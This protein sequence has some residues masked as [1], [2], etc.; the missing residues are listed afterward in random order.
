M[1]NLRDLWY[2][3]LGINT[4]LFKKINSLSNEHIYAGIMKKIT[5][6]GQV[7]LLPYYL[8]AIGVYAVLSLLFKLSTRKGG[9]KYHI[10]MWIN[11]FIM[12]GAGLVSTK[13]TTSYLKEYFSYPRPYVMLSSSEVIQLEGQVT[14]EAYQS[15]PSGHVII[16]TVLIAAL[17]P[18]LN[19]NFRWSGIFAISSVAW[20]R[21][22]LGVHFPMDVVSGFTI[23]LI[24]MLLIR[25][26]LYSITNRLFLR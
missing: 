22:A 12:L 9:I 18:A 26:V 14:K 8:G 21:I 2:D 1:S 7:D 13:Y 15:F 19:E 10:F 17:W 20:S 16:I 11:I 6:L 5:L 24:Q 3:W 25:Y 4:W 23:A